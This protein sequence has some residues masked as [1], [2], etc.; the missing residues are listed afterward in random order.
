[1]TK[2]PTAIILTTMVYFVLI[3]LALD[4]YIP[5]QP[6]SLKVLMI[7]TQGWIHVRSVDLNRPLILSIIVLSVITLS[8]MGFNRVKSG[9][10][11]VISLKEHNT[12]V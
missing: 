2:F 9:G 7:G 5:L 4:I 12:A 6:V 10:S 1:V 3:S 11:N 8:C